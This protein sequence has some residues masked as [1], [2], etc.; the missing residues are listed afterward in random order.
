VGDKIA[1]DEMLERAVLHALMDDAANWRGL[2]YSPGSLFGS[3]GDVRLSIDHFTAPRGNGSSYIN[4]GRRKLFALLDRARGTRAVDPVLL[5]LALREERDEETAAELWA[6]VAVPYS[7]PA[8]RAYAVKLE[9]LRQRRE[10]R[11]VTRAQSEAPKEVAN[12]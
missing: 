8:L 11:A 9:E 5:A 10:H 2:S 7:V 6:I 1:R 3:P 12:G 4:T